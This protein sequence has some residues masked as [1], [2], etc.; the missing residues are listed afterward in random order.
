MPTYL[1]KTVS[2]SDLQELLASFRTAYTAAGGKDVEDSDQ[3]II[4]VLEEE[5]VITVAH[6]A[7]I[8]KFQAKVEAAK[9]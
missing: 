8:G 5:K 7:S 2:D 1:G 3:P 4:N 9:G 6:A